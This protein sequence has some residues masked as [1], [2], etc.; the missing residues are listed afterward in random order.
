[1]K[2]E[3]FQWYVRRPTRRRAVQFDPAPGQVDDLPPGVKH[4]RRDKGGGPPVLC[5]YVENGK[6][7]MDVY[8]GDFVIYGNRGEIY[9]VP[10]DIFHENYEPCEAGDD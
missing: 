4:E 6:G 5:Y 7:R 1:M 9:P 8:P 10:A 3:G 2:V